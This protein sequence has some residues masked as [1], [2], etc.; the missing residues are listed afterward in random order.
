MFDFLTGRKVYYLYST[1]QPYVNISKYVLVIIY[2]YNTLYIIIYM[3]VCKYFIYVM[4]IAYSC[5]Y[6]TVRI[7]PANSCCIY[8][9]TLHFSASTCLSAC[10]LVSVI[11]SV[12]ICLYLSFYP[13]A[14]CALSSIR[15]SK[16]CIQV[17]VC[18]FLYKITHG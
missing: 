14:A 6:R 13:F 4:C 10:V 16:G 1:T 17:H 5:K 2:V 11:L 9:K 15:L 18:W 3:Y 8:I 12:S 7:V